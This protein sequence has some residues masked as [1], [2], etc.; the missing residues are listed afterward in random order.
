M[1]IAEMTERLS[2]MHGA[3]RKANDILFDEQLQQA[4]ADLRA[5]L[6]DEIERLETRPRRGRGSERGDATSP[7]KGGEQTQGAVGSGERQE[8]RGA[9]S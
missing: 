1:R 6:E 4:E 3:M 5:E 8:A 9:H 7:E 2:G